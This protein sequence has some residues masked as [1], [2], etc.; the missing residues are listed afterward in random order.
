MGSQSVYANY[1]EATG[2]VDAIHISGQRINWA[3][4][5]C[6]ARSPKEMQ[7]ETAILTPDTTRKPMMG[8]VIRY[9]GSCVFSCH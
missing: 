4:I 9:R 8:M 2:A 7:P 6:E 5:P 1:E 3:L